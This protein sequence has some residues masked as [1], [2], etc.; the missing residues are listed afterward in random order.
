MKRFLALA[1]ALVMLFCLAACGEDKKTDDSGSKSTTIA[2]TTKPTTPSTP[3]PPV[4]GETVAGAKAGL[5]IADLDALLE[6]LLN[7]DAGTDIE[8][9]YLEM[10][11]SDEALLLALGAKLMGE[12]LY[13][14][15]FVGE[16][17][18]VSIPALLEKNY[19]IATA[20]LVELL[21]A[22]IEDAT[23][24]TMTTI[25]PEVVIE[26]I[27]KY[28]TMLLTEVASAE[29]ITA[30]E[31]D[32]VITISGT[33]NS[34]AIATII[35]N[36][37]EASCADDDFFELMGAMSGMTAEEFKEGFLASKP[38]KDELLTQMKAAMAA[39]A[40]NIEINQLVLSNGL[41]VAA[42]ME[43]ST[44]V[45]TDDGDVLGEILLDYDLTAGEIS[46]YVVEDGFTVAEF[47]VGDGRVYL[48][49]REDGQISSIDLQL[50][51]TGATLTVKQNSVTVVDATFAITAN[52]FSL[53]MTSNGETMSLELA[54][55]DNAITLTMGMRGSVMVLNAKVTDAGAEGSLTMD[56]TEIGKIVFVKKVEGT[57]ISYTLSTL[58]IQ[59][60]E[61]DFSK[62]GLSIYVDTDA[63]VPAV[64]AYDDITTLT[65]AELEAALEK[66]MSDHAELVEKLET[67]FGGVSG[68]EIITSPDYDL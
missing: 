15:L 7:G 16:D 1:L 27:G 51:E 49:S 47:V 56:G 8:N 61:V 52:G 14:N 43:L 42:S 41:P 64:P 34:D 40:M 31:A 18:V 28:Y 59:G 21:K 53:T 67:L 11:G 66:F 38:S 55:T 23:A 65:E 6:P 9:F 26:L 24:G 50:T 25:D 2:T 37:L 44:K 22:Q 29:G 33:L 32:G 36:I 57:K 20:D 10:G 68:G 17:V 48:S 19:G 12:D 45:S 54:V 58:S 5:S 4:T 62:G 30:T 35:V 63:Q 39:Q 60:T 13:A 3:T 46:L